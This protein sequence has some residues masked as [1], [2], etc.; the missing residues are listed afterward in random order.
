[1]KYHEM[2]DVVFSSQVCTISTYRLTVGHDR[3]T[4][5][6]VPLTVTVTVTV[7]VPLNVTVNVGPYEIYH[8]I[9]SS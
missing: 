1:M 7:T 2:G 4:V 8:F 5:V 9:I 6:T 3:G